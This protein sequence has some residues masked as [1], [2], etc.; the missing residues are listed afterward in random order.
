MKRYTT[1][2]NKSAFGLKKLK[3][4]IFLLFIAISAGAQGQALPVP[5]LNL[6]DLFF[7]AQDLAFEQEGSAARELC[8]QILEINPDYHDASI[9][10]ARTLAWE[11]RYDE[12][13][14]ILEEVIQ[15]SPSNRSALMA[16]TDIHAWAGNYRE[17]ID[18]LDK[19][20][21]SDPNNPDLLFRKAQLLNEL[22]EYQPTVILLYQILDI[23]P[24]HRDAKEL[25]STIEVGRL[26]NF[27]GVGYRG[28]FFEMANSWHL[29][30]AEYGRRTNAFG[31]VISRVNVADRFGNTGLQFEVDAYP[32]LGPGTY[33][34]LNAGYSPHDKLFPTVRAGLEVFQ[35]L[36]S[37]WE[38]SAG[39]RLLNFTEN[40]LLILTGSISKYYRQYYFSFRPFFTFASNTP[41]SQSYFFTIRRYFSS[42]DHHLSVTAGTGFS[43]DDDALIG[44]E[45]YN[46]ESNKVMLWYQQKATPQLIIRAGAGYQYYKG[47]VWGNK[48]TV[49]AGVAYLF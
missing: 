33:M 38:A 42:P 27:V 20:I 36:P 19:V 12:A 31:T 7:Q 48:Y 29:F 6:D 47:G 11:Q 10:M 5:Q 39:L 17:A 16:I 40:D 3:G 35:K 44:A 9:L 4:L 14:E 1:K 41:S 18:Y 15:K 49:E 32:S 24:T 23:D 45:V 37:A 2:I 25:L 43:A 30:Y 13:A 34:Y 26:R 22:G 8:R 46:L 28:D 21:V